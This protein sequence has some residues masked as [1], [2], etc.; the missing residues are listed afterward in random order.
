[1]GGDVV[2]VI[3]LA[4]ACESLSDSDTRDPG[5]LLGVAPLKQKIVHEEQINS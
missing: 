1:M 3:E 2:Q 4:C 5:A